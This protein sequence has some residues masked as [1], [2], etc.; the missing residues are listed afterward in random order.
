MT[1][2]RFHE[3]ISGSYH[4]LSSFQIEFISVNTQYSNKRQRR[5]SYF[6]QL[7]LSR[8]DHTEQIIC[9]VMFNPAY[10]KHF[11]HNTLNTE[12]DVDEFIGALLEQKRAIRNQTQLQITNEQAIDEPALNEIRQGIAEAIRELKSWNYQSTK[13]Q[14]RIPNLGTVYLHPLRTE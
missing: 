11:I 14:W 2:E 7:P 10:S 9:Q 6:F 8:T 12:G 13:A 1:K 4:R 5:G 3:I